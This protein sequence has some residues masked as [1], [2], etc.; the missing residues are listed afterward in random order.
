MAR[1]G[2]S[3]CFIIRQIEYLRRH[4]AVTG[5]EIGQLGFSMDGHCA[6]RLAQQEGLGIAAT[7]TFYAA[8]SGNFSPTRSSFLCHFAEDDDWVSAA[9]VRK[10]AGRLD[11]ARVP[12]TFRRYPGTRH[13]FFESDCTDAFAP[14]AAEL[15]W[16]RTPRFPKAGLPI[17]HVARPDSRC[18]GNSVR[19]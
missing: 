9:V 10:L 4:E 5:F 3:S 17:G 6:F 2:E 8:R 1:E 13:W 12:V 18:K 11:S 15:A 14:R 7:V 19:R 16:K